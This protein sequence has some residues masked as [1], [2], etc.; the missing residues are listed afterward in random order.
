MNPIERGPR[1]RG[2][3]LW[4]WQYT[5]QPKTNA[6]FLLFAGAI[7]LFISSIFLALM[8]NYVYRAHRLAS[9]GKFATGAVVTKVMHQASE[10]G[11]SNTSYEVDYVFTTADGIKIESN[12]TIDP[13]AWD[14]LKEGGPVQIEYASSKPRIN[15]VGATSG[16]III[17]YIVVVVA[18]VMWLVGATLAVKGLRGTWSV[19]ARSGKPLRSV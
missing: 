6:Q 18:S 14:Q 9:E 1:R 12:D 4:R 17:G 5:W 15:E 13:D 3:L 11:T 8:G 19:P 2:I 10:N 16:P 7:L